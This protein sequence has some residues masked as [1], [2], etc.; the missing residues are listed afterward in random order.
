M[1]NKALRIMIADPEHLQRLRLERDFN[2]QGYY[3]VA[4]VSS[5]QDM[6]NLLEFGD[7]GFDLVLINASLAGTD[8]F[9]LYDFCLDHSLMGQAFV[10]DLPPL[11]QPTT[12][13]TKINGR[14]DFISVQ[15]PDGALITPLRRAADS[16]RQSV[17]S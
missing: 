4:P 8:G 1:I 12:L 6:L 2:R 13:R 17:T 15:L 10:Y 5:L 3:A 16:S 9:N 7:R 11:S 14:V